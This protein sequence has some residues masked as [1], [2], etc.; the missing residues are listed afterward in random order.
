MSFHLVDKIVF[1]PKGSALSGF[2]HDFFHGLASRCGNFLK[3]HP[4]DV[5][6]AEQR[7]LS[8]V[9][10]LY[11]KPAVIQPIVNFVVQEEVRR[12]IDTPPCCMWKPAKVERDSTATF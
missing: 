5:T 10:N 9:L 7:E 11:R 2:H 12:V 8:L 1:F 3:C 6:M 4:T